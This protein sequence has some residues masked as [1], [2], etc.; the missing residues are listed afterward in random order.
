MKS[1]SQHWS[2]PSSCVINILLGLAWA[3]E[4]AVMESGASPSQQ[5]PPQAMFIY[6]SSSSYG[7]G[8]QLEGRGPFSLSLLYPLCYMALC[9]W[10][11]CK[12]TINMYGCEISVGQVMYI[13]WKWTFLLTCAQKREGYQKPLWLA[14]KGN[15]EMLLFWHLPC[16]KE[17][18]ILVGKKGDRVKEW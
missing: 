13:L 14:L 11:G 10:N 6:S 3:A 12:G 4:Q 16:P 8:A 17:D 5:L 1:S 7:N 9:D 18:S 2:P 15:W